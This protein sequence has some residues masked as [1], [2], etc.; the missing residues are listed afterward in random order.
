VPSSVVFI[1]LDGFKQINDVFGHAAGDSVL[2]QFAT[3][4]RQAL[5]PDCLAARTGGDEFIVVLRGM[6]LHQADDWISALRRLVA[7]QPFRHLEHEFM[8]RFSA[9]RAQLM[10]TMTPG[11]AI[12]A[13][14]R[15]CARAKTGHS[16]PLA[17]ADDPLLRLD[18]AAPELALELQ[19]Q[20]VLAAHDQATTVGAE[21]L[22]RLRDCKGKLR[23][24]AE[25]LPAARARG[26]ASKIDLWVLTQALV[27]RSAQAMHDCAA[28]APFRVIKLS[29][30]SLHDR[31]FQRLALE[32]LHQ[33]TCDAA[34]LRFELN[35]RLAL[36]D[37]GSI[38]E[39]IDS[40]RTAGV[41]VVLS[42]LTQI[43]VWMPQ[44]SR[45]LPAAIKVDASW[46]CNRRDRAA[47][48]SCVRGLID[49][50]RELGIEA[51]ATRIESEQALECARQ[52]GFDQVQ[53]FLFG[54]PE[55]VLLDTVTG[56][57]L[58]FRNPA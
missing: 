31:R 2:R 42:G 8:L 33:H 36:H 20:T 11:L 22:L 19:A 23:L 26:L 46:F 44:L 16:A 1:D 53:G 13:A 54:P 17:Q 58:P 41:R 43:P 55:P 47:A 37:P 39:F 25:F 15:E 56:L 38:T 28:P 3:R 45:L 12:D 9:G 24:P 48:Q 51:C 27:G 40:A 32:L 10:P 7:G 57:P 14:D 35:G 29:V 50:C 4:L 5:S 21:W 18:G 49:T 6:R 52:C 34:G 30:E